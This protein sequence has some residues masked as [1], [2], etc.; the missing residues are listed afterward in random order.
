MVVYAVSLMI[1]GHLIKLLELTRSYKPTLKVMWLIWPGLM[2]SDM[3]SKSDPLFGVL[4]I[5]NQKRERYISKIMDG[6]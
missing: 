1:L 6:G 4:L 3:R 5:D 2:R